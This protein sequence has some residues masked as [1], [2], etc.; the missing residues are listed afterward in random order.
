MMH[1]DTL[2]KNWGGEENTGVENVVPQKT[3]GTGGL[4][5]KREFSKEGFWFGYVKLLFLF[6][7]QGHGSRGSCS[8]HIAE[9]RFKYS[10]T[11]CMFVVLINKVDEKLYVHVLPRNPPFSWNKILSKPVSNTFCYIQW[12]FWYILQT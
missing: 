9:V 10:I 3:Q 5:E 11:L 7:F 1:F 12:A 6:H 8:S 4:T 2:A